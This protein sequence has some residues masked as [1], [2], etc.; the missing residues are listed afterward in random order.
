MTILILKKEI[1]GKEVIK[2]SVHSNYRSMSTYSQH[3]HS[4]GWIYVHHENDIDSIR[5]D[6]IEITALDKPNYSLF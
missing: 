6:K 2:A 4:E 1:D 5:I 3:K